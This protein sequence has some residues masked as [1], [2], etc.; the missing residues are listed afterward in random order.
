MRNYFAVQDSG[1]FT[2][3]DCLRRYQKKKSNIVKSSDL[4]GHTIGPL[5]AIYFSPNHNFIKS[6]GQPSCW[7]CIACLSVRSKY[8]SLN[9]SS[10]CTSIFWF[11]RPSMKKGPRRPT[12]KKCH[13]IHSLYGNTVVYNW[14]ENLDF[15]N[16]ERK[17]HHL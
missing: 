16:F 9:F 12:R 10:I 5:V 6:A 7:K 17:Q 14:S 4:E 15:G 11:K 13:T 2:Y 1:R 8:C 3:F